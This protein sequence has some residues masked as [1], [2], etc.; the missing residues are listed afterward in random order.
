MLDVEVARDGCRVR[1]PPAGRAKTLYST[2]NTYLPL[3]FAA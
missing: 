2:E 1:S 3:H